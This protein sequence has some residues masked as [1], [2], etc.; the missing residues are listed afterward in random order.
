LDVL[1]HVAGQFKMLANDG[2]FRPE[3]KLQRN[4]RNLPIKRKLT[5]IIMIATTVALLL[6]SAGFVAYEWISFQQTMRQDLFTQAKMLG[7]LST[8]ALAQG[9]EKEARE[10]LNALTNRTHIRAAA[11]YAGTNLQT[12]R[13]FAVYPANAGLN[14]FP[15]HPDNEGYHN[16]NF[17]DDS[18]VIFHQ[19]HNAGEP[20]GFVYLKSDLREVHDRLKHYAVMFAI[21]IGT[22]SIFTYFLSKRLQR[23]ISKPIFH[24][25]QTAKA[26]SREKNYSARVEKHAEDE[27]GE[28]IDGFNEMLAQIQRRDGDLQCAKDELEKRV[29]ERTRDLELEIAERKRAEEALQSQFTRTYLLN[30]ITQV[31]SERQDLES[32]L[33]VVLRQLEDHLGI[34]LG[35]V[36]LF[37]KTSETLS[38]AA[39]RLKNSLLSTKLD[40]QEGMVFSLEQTGLRSCKHGEPLITPDTRKSAAL[41]AEKFAAAGFRST[42]ALPL[43]VEGKMFGTLIVARLAADSL[44]ASECDFLNTL[45]EQVALA[46]HQAQLHEE[47]EQAYNELRQTQQT[48]M[49]Q[50]RLKALGQMASGIAHDVNNALSPI[51]GFADLLSRGELALSPNGKKYLNYIKTAGEDIAHIVARLRE[52]YR[53][54]DDAEKLH[55]LNLNDLAAQ[56]IDMTRPRWRDIPQGRGI[57]IEVRTDFDAS[58]PTLVGIE[59]EVREALTNLILNAV[60]A[61][62]NGGTITVRTY[63][64]TRGLSHNT[65][66]HVMLEVGDTGIGM[67][68][69]TRKHCLE[70]FFSTKGQRGTGLGLAM[71]YG[72]ME[73]HEGEIEVGSELGKGTTMKLI[74][75][76]RRMSGHGTLEQGKEE[77]VGPLHI[78]CIDDEP[79]LRELL[80]EILERDGHEVVVSDSGHAGVQ[81]FR[82]AQTK[83]AFDIVLTDLGMPYFDGRQVAKAIKRESSATPV[84]MLTGWGAFMKEDGDVPSQVDGILSKPPRSAELRETLHRLIRQ[85]KEAEKELDGKVVNLPLRTPA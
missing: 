15:D 23:V 3:I 33:Y 44:S 16:L 4:V 73:R 31:I 52:F 20:T 85:R 48:V 45:G 60:D 38:V 51:V 74:F 11:V 79:L 27:L 39:L 37:E 19:I 59:S 14:H 46:A 41:L 10:I 69:E 77:P 47:L 8:A 40:L 53:Q 66:T 42:A 18:L 62:P 78:L 57:M 17:K 12:A 29:Q 50:E 43:M 68:E 82:V 21:L 24:L 76:V 64:T 30:Q 9:N 36:C 81:A 61:V 35:V 28:L 6:I 55:Q 22:V 49:R 13:L 63:V 65:P 7:D 25:V 75:P 71:V 2:G 83:K 58:L 1:I 56:V 32:I 80:R 72:V 34:D 67:D 84:I 26:V 54:R 5:L 70:P